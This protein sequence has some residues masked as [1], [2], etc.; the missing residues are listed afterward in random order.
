[1]DFFALLR[2][3]GWNEAFRSEALAL[4]M[5]PE[6]VPARITGEER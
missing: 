1:M 6:L 3:L 4:G 2:P 5:S